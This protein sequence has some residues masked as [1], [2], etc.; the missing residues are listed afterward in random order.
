MYRKIVVLLTALIVGMLGAGCAGRPPG[1]EKAKGQPVPPPQACFHPP[2]DKLC[3][4]IPHDI[5]ETFGLGYSSLNARQQRDFDNFSW[6]SFVA[7][8]WPANNDGTPSAKSILEDA[9]AP[10]VWEFYPS[11]FQLF[12][13]ILAGENRTTPEVRLR[14][15][16]KK[17][18]RFFTMLAT[19][20]NP[21]NLKPSSFTE[22][23]TDLPLIDR[24]LNYVVYDIA[25]N[26]I[27]FDYIK[28]NQLNTKKGQEAFQEQGKRISFP[29]GAYEDSEKKTGGSI[30]AM[31]IKT[32]WRLLDPK[33][34][35]KKKYYTV[36][37]EI[38]VDTAH[39]ES[40]QP[41]TIPATLG[42]VG[43]HVIQ[44]TSGPP[45]QPQDW[46]WS[47]FEHVENAPLAGNAREATDI[48]LPLPAA[49]TPPKTV[50]RTYSFFNADFKGP[51]NEPPPLPKGET[52][53]KWAA[54]PPYAATYAFDKKYGTQV[55]RCWKIFPA[56]EDVNKYFQKLLKGTV[57]ENYQLIG[58]QWMG[59]VE[60]PQLENGNIPRYLSNTTLETYLQ[61]KPIGSCLACHSYAQ[62]AVQ[63]QSAN[64][65]FL[66][67]RVR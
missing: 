31:E 34:E 21:P 3:S 30:G 23:G 44:R 41:L 13:Q 42:L 61:F 51:T 49:G 50:D 29:L 38:Y 47:T 35:D 28:N 32:A 55:V 2:Y 10:R 9:A 59:G 53:Y 15:S 60:N 11:P 19:R 33:K 54:K 20:S 58:S 7:L 8:N 62:T 26:S 67:M 12:G 36:E 48:S 18:R 64:F 45:R 27:E 57:W 43:F 52:V 56:T 16:R 66:L 6:Q 24:N 1:A 5:T 40:G 22:A 37:G 39:S 4:S 17:P 14:A 46:I 25:V 63:G 65:S